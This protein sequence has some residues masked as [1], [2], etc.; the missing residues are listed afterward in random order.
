MADKLINAEGLEELVNFITLSEQKAFSFD[1][2][3]SL[4]FF[5]SLLDYL[6]LEEISQE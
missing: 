4:L 3:F 6:N 2:D 5:S 1:E